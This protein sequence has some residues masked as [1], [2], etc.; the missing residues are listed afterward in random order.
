MKTLTSLTLLLLLGFTAK[1]NDGEVRIMLDSARTVT[2]QAD[3]KG[4]QL[5]E[6]QT[7]YYVQ[8]AVVKT[9]TFNTTPSIVRGRL[10][11]QKILDTNNYPEIYMTELICTAQNENVNQGYCS[12]DLEIKGHKKAI[13]ASY[14]TINQKIVIQFDFLLSDYNI[15]QRVF[16]FNIKNTAHAEIKINL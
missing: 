6:T 2:I 5:E 16:L 8:K 14:K 13:S 10:K 11:S 3:V 12:G 9:S 1:A 7:G 15:A 4:I